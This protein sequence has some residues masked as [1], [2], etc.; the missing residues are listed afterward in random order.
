MIQI[1]SPPTKKKNYDMDII[2]FIIPFL[3]FI[4]HVRLHQLL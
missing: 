1:Q 3:L 4:N 2:F